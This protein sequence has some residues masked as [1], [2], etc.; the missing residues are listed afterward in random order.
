MPVITLRINEDLLNKIEKLA[1]K[2][3]RKKSQVIKEILQK[4]L[5]QEKDIKEYIELM[6][7]GKKTGNLS[8]KDIEKWFENT[9]PEFE[10][11]EKAIEH[12]RKRIK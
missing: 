2:T 5:E 6:S 3:G 12:S 1:K 9:E 11:W 10:S 4:E 7:K 8:L